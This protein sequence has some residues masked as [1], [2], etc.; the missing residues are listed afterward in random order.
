MK[1]Y[2]KMLWYSNTFF[3]RESRTFIAPWKFRDYL[4]APFA[5]LTFMKLQMN[6]HGQTMIDPLDDE[7]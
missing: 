7:S 1:N 3:W 2:I 4:Q 6:A 5:W